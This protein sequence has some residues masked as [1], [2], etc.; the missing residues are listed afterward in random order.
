MA[1]L[2]APTANASFLTRLGTTYIADSAGVLRDV[3]QGTEVTDLEA[4]GCA[5]VVPGRY[6]LFV[7]VDADMNSTEDQK[8]SSSLGPVT[9]YS[10]SKVVVTGASAPVTAAAGGI[11]TDMEK[12]GDAVVAAGQSFALAGTDLSE[13]VVAT[14]APLCATKC[15][16]G[17]LYLSLT[18]ANGAPATCNVFV[19]GDVL[20]M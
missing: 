9:G 17:P 7:L 4:M 15:F 19:Y 6:P 20:A 11:Y 13:M 2:L 8:F 18:S 5:L 1:T 12:G 3:P 14:L 16:Q 10:L